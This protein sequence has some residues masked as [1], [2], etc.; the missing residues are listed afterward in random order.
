MLVSVLLAMASEIAL[1]SK[2]AVRGRSVVEL[3]A[4]LGEAGCARRVDA[5]VPFFNVTG[6]IT[7]AA[8]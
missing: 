6:V 4:E 3:D 5:L 7:G 2:P 8:S 1:R